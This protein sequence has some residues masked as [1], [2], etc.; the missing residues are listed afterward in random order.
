[1]D[2]DLRNVT[3]LF[4]RVYIK[5][6]K[7]YTL[8]TGYDFNILLNAI[9]ENYPNGD[10][11]NLLETDPKSGQK[12]VCPRKTR[13]F[14]LRRIDYYIYG[15]SQRQADETMASFVSL[16]QIKNIGYI[17]SGKKRVIPAYSVI[18]LYKI[19]CL[20]PKECREREDCKNFLQLLYTPVKQ[21]H[22]HH[23]DDQLA[24][25]FEECFKLVKE[26]MD[27]G[28]EDLSISEFPAIP[29]T[30]PDKVEDN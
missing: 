5:F 29:R 6:E 1:M 7:N 15:I 16:K 23:E 2:L 3:E 9:A 26:A 21:Y 19:F 20:L 28:N 30:H 25:F 13:N 8:P 27:N 11:A 22:L 12:T 4:N 14:L 17:F 24:R 18:I 10:G